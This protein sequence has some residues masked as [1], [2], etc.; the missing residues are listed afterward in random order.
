M[1]R[2]NGSLD[3]KNPLKRNVKANKAI[4]AY[5]NDF[6]LKKTRPAGLALFFSDL[7]LSQSNIPGK[8][9]SPSA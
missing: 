9:M 8:I 4:F 2:P 3:N 7:T 5:F 1:P 6:R